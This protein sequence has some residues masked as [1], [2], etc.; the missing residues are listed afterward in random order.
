VAYL[1]ARYTQIGTAFV[2]VEQLRW[3]HISTSAGAGTGET[4]GHKH[5]F[6]HDG[7]GDLFVEVSTRATRRPNSA[8]GRI[9]PLMLIHTPV[10]Y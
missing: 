9:V 3:V 1:L 5:V 2:T 10:F 7:A 6:R 4:V 8:D